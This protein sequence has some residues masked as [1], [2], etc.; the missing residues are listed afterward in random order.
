[1][2]D[3]H[4]F[5]WLAADY[6][7]TFTNTRL[8]RLLRDRVQ[9]IFA[10]YFQTG[11]HVLELTCGTGEDAVWLAQR[12]VFVTATDGSAEMV[13]LTA[14]KAVRT[15]VKDNVDV[16]QLSW[17][18]LVDQPQQSV[19]QGTFTGIFS[20]FGGV[21]TI[22]NWRALAEALARIA[23]P[24]ATLIFVVMGPYCPWELVWHLLHGE[25]ATAVRRFKKNALATI[26][27][28]TLPIWYPSARQLRRDFSPWFSHISTESLGLWLPPSYLGH[29]VD[30][31]P[32]LF[33]RLNQLER[34]T[35]RLTGGAGDHFVLLL[36]RRP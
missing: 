27:N 8:G 9:T 23:Q 19:T 33:A 36:R 15:H 11:D 12:G 34:K 31:W 28:N 20:N 26:G 6:D 24:G 16:A 7:A 10:H 3:P 4:A 5:D 29:L 32:S 30:R 14:Q 17:Q 21:N 25:W 18:Q 2:I 35:A 22:N 13:A 1:M